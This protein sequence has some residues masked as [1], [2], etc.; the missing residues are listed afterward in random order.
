[1]KIRALLLIIGTWLVTGCS[2][3][4]TDNPD[5]VEQKINSLLSEMTLDEKIGQMQQVNDGF[6]G[7]EEATK[8]AIRDGKVGS[9]L[10]IV[11][12]E[13]AAEFQRVAL[14]ESKHG[15]PLKPHRWELT[16]HLHQ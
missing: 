9:F 8:Q 3:T 6:F 1:M 16:G 5:P 11:G 10:N 13:R 12:A 4:L 2:T 15:I 14:E 7:D